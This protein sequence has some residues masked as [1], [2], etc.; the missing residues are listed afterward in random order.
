MEIRIGS[1]HYKTPKEKITNSILNIVDEKIKDVGQIDLSDYA[2]KSELPTKVSE[3]ENDEGYITSSV[4]GIPIVEE[5]G[6]DDPIG[7][8]V[9]YKQN[10]EISKLETTEQITK[11]IPYIKQEYGWG[12]L[13]TTDKDFNNDFNFDFD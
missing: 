8:I 7:T 2:K 13:E 3:L 12:S 1:D 10:I 11:A 6:L 4:G 5:L 9:S